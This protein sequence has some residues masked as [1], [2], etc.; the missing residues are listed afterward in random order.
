MQ[1]KLKCVCVFFHES[2][3]V[4]SELLIINNKLPLIF[5]FIFYPVIY[6]AQKTSEVQSTGIFTVYFMKSAHFHP[7]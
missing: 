7:S 6:P 1:K 5:F 3:L 4:I 2:P